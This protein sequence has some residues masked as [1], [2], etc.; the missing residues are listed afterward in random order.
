MRNKESE[1][2]VVAN[3]NTLTLTIDYHAFDLKGKK[4]C[5]TI[6]TSRIE[7]KMEATLKTATAI[8]RTNVAEDKLQNLEKVASQRIFS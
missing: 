1:E 5:G 3:I 4:E 7:E 2:D 6:E 8:A